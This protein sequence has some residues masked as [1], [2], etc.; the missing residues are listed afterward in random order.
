LET[1]YLTVEAQV[2]QLFWC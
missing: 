2:A 1:D